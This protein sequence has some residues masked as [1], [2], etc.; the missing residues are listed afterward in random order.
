MLKKTEGIVINSMRYRDTS[1]IVK[2]FT[3]ELGLK[4]YIIN[5][6][7]KAGAKSKAALYQPM[8]ILDLVVYEK[9]NSGLQRI[10]ESKLAHP[11]ALIPYEFPRTSIALFL[12]EAVAKSIYENYHNQ[13]LFDWL[14]N[15]LL[16]LDR[17]TQEIKHFPLVFLLE[18]ARFIGFGPETPHE[19][20]DESRSL[21]FDAQELSHAIEY[22]E[23]LMKDSYSCQLKVKKELR[24]KLLDFLLVFYGEQLDS[25]Q[26]WKSIAIIRNVMAQ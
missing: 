23:C 21:P 9:E 1:L 26:V 3:R 24:G 18:M 6:V 17:N 4:S 22:L 25:N 2:I 20:L 7:R 11:F 5:G 12:A 13:Q 10:S 14:K 16:C 8:T 19:L 15:S